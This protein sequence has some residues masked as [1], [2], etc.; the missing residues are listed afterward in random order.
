MFESPGAQV[1]SQWHYV[2]DDTYTIRREKVQRMDVRKVSR[3]LNAVR[4]VLLGWGSSIGFSMSSILFL[5]EKLPVFQTELYNNWHFF[6][7]NRTQS[8]KNWKR[9]LN[10]IRKLWLIFWIFRLSKSQDGLNIFLRFFSCDF[11]N[12]K[13]FK[14][15]SLE[16][17][18]YIQFAI[19]NPRWCLRLK[20]YTQTQ[21]TKR[22]NT[23]HFKTITSLS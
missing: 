8:T 23:Y 12:K 20:L 7:P 17:S 4:L 14:K 15:W 13:N 5:T 3:E 18:N 9:P 22:N 16:G 21:K 19:G 11:F 10:E 6:P 2:L 1:A